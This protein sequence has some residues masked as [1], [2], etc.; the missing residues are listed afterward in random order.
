[1]RPDSVEEFTVG[2]CRV[3]IEHDPDPKSPRDWDNLGTMVCW[4]RR[5][6]LGDEQPKCDPNRYLEELAGP[7]VSE[8]S[9]RV[10]RILDCRLT[11]RRRARVE[12]ILEKAIARELNEGFV[13]LPLYLYD[14]SGI[15]MS[16]GAFS[17]PWDSGQVGFIY[18]S[19]VKVR[20]EVSQPGAE[21]DTEFT[22]HDGVKETL[23]QYAERVLTIEVETY[24]QYLTGQVY[25]YVVEDEDGEHLDSCGG[26]Y[27]DYKLSYIRS[28]ATSSAEYHSKKIEDLERETAMAETMP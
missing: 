22:R 27:D 5:Y 20:N 12:R 19:L 4:H 25:G 9:E 17:C 16:T 7:G 24:D 13:R 18:V 11:D 2:R 8:L 14:H 28:E 15:T 23:R 1:M 10:D 26:F 6:N 21:W 3:K